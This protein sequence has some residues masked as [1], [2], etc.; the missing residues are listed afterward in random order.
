[1]HDE[2]KAAL[3]GLASVLLAHPEALRELK[4]YGDMPCHLADVIADIERGDEP[5]EIPTTAAY[6]ARLEEATGYTIRAGVHEGMKCWWLVDP[7]GDVEGDPWF[8]WADLVSDTLDTVEDH[9]RELA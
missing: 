5:E 3:S 2:V 8:R 4:V 1:M 7:C 6:A 9:E